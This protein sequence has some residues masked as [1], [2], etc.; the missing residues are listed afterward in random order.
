MVR[1]SSISSV[2][3]EHHRT[4]GAPGTLGVPRCL[5]R[6]TISSMRRTIFLLAC[7][8]LAAASP[9]DDIRKAEKDWAAAVTSRDFPALQ[10]IYADQLIYAHSTGAVES[11]QQ[12]LERLKTGAQQYDQIEFQDTIIRGYG[13]SAVAHSHVHITGKSDGRP[14]DD[15]L[16]ML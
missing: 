6:S 8:L 4:W 14:F 13:D 7:A 2:L 5:A 11:K 9:E 15:R 1:A 3:W 12:Y 16:M 10:R